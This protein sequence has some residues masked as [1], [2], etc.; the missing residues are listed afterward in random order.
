MYLNFCSSARLRDHAVIRQTRLASND[1]S[2]YSDVYSTINEELAELSDPFD[3]DNEEEDAAKETKKK[4]NLKKGKSTTSLLKGPAKIQMPEPRHCKTKS[5][6]SLAHEMIPVG[7]SNA[8]AGS[9]QTILAAPMHAK[10]S[11]LLT[12]TPE[13]ASAAAGK[14]KSSQQSLAVLAPD[15]APPLPMRSSKCRPPARPPYPSSLVRAVQEITQPL[16]M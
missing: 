7:S 4:T 11:S 15:M 13:T 10:S 6:T 12:V 2:I 1:D 14:F 8:G 3:G 5:M 9:T 16:H